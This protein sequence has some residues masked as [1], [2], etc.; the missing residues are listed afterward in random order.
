MNLKI[1]FK[2]G[3]K[4][5]IW[6]MGWEFRRISKNN[7]PQKTTPPPL[8][9][10]PLEALLQRQSGKNIAFKCPIDLCRAENGFGFGPSH[11]HPFVAT[12]KQF[13]KNNDLQYDESI[14]KQFY[15]TWQ[16]GNAAEAIAGF[17]DAPETYYKLPAYCAYLRPW[18]S[19]SPDSFDKIS[20]WSNRGNAEHGR[21]DLQWRV[22]GLHWFGPVSREKGKFEFERLI[23]VYNSIKK[24]GYDRLF[25]DI[26]VRILRSD[27]DYIFTTG[28]GGL[29]RTAAIAALGHKTFPAQFKVADFL[30]DTKDVEYWPLVRSGLW[31]ENEALAYVDHL[32][33]FDSRSWAR[34]IGLPLNK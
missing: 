21:P 31:S 14:L 16:P 24:N 6:E 19:A 11:W 29:H 4:R 26:G 10:N 12:L 23:S 9:D 2:K 30:A 18:T 5:A 28:G 22:H 8:I 20:I 3:A 25:G 13:E 34:R 15:Q 17:K 33:K 7:T 1:L 27:E 32:F